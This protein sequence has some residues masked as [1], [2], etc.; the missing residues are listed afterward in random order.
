MA[1]LLACVAQRLGALDQDQEVK[2]AAI[3]CAGACIA[4]LGDVAPAEASSLLQVRTASFIHSIHCLR[5]ERLPY[6]HFT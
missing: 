5:C 4:R 6:R 3:T 2:E 1:P